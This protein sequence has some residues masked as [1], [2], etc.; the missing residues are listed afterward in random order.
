LSAPLLE[1]M[2]RVRLLCAPA[3]SGKTALMAE[4]LLQAPEGCAVHWLPL[5]GAALTSDDFCRRL[6]Q[7]LGLAETD[8]AGMLA[9]VARWPT[10]AWL[11]IDDYCRLPDPA[12]DALLDRL[13]AVSSPALTWWIGCRRRPQCNWP[14]LLLDDVLYECEPPS[15]A[16]NQDEIARVLVHLPA[17]QAAN[18]ACRI[19]QRTAGWCAGVRMALL[20]KCD[21]SQKR[22]PQERVDTLLDYLQHELFNSLTPEQTEVW[23]VLAHLPRF[24]DELCEHLFGAGEGAQHL[25]ALQTLGCFIE[26]WQETSDWLQIFPPLSR[27]IRDGQWS[28]GRSWHRRACQWFAAAED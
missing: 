14:R 19:V 15:L 4:C 26:P 16:L 27:V 17:E 11:F 21:W 23:R 10:S 6:A 22:Q 13:L 25:H 18:V 20:Q 9:A 7:A 5:A 12:L 1:S 3:G 2:A 28:S 8:E 24:N